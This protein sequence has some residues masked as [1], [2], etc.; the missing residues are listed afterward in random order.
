MKCNYLK[1]MALL[2]FFIFSKTNLTAQKKQNFSSLIPITKID[3]KR[4]NASDTS[5]LDVFIFFSP[6]CPICKVLVPHLNEIKQ[7]HK[8]QPVRFY[9]V[10][11]QSLHYTKKDLQKNEIIDSLSID[12]YV[13]RKNILTNQLQATVTPQV[14]VNQQSKIIYSGK[15]N[16]LYLSVGVQKKTAI[17]Y[18]LLEVLEAYFNNKK[19]EIENNSPIGCYITPMKS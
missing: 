11:P 6:D 7:K 19:I 18:F 13:D 3:K 12:I 9:I 5:C 16:D 1:M 10:I 4:P 15:I 2:V 17:Q 8:E 14:I